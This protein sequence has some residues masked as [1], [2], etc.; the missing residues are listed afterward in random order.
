MKWLVRLAIV[1]TIVGLGLVLISCGSNSPAAQLQEGQRITARE[2]WDVMKGEVLKW[3]PGSLIITARPPSRPGKEDLDTDGR[4]SA[5]RFVVAPEGDTLP[6]IYSLDTTVKP[7]KPNRTEQRRPVAPANVDPD[8]WTIDSPEAMQIAL[9]N[10]LEE[11]MAD[12]PGFQLRTMVFELNATVE[13]GAHWRI[14]ATQV[15]DKFTIR[16]SALDGSV[17]ETIITP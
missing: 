12:H 5:W 6:G 17:I 10:G 8:T 16:I 3:K 9:D 2:A 7:I 11:W 1:A 13:H 14:E 15:L 4:S